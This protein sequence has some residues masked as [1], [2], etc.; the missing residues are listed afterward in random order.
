M[1]NLSPATK[2]RLYSDDLGKMKYG[3][4]KDLREIGELNTLRKICPVREFSFYHTLEVHKMLV[5]INS[6]LRKPFLTRNRR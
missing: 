5:S 1:F 4:L 6:S 2:R 3:Q